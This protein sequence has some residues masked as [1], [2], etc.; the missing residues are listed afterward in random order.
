MLIALIILGAFFY[1]QTGYQLGKASWNV[2]HK[3]DSGSLAA[4]L[5]FPISSMDKAVGVSGQA[6]IAEFAD[7]KREQYQ[8]LMA[9]SWPWKFACN[10]VIVAAIGLLVGG[11]KLIQGPDR[12]ITRSLER[13]RLR[14][15][16]RA[17]LRAA[18]E[19]AH[20]LPEDSEE[21]AIKLSD[22]Y[23]HLLGEEEK[24]RSRRLEIE[25][26][27]EFEKIRDARTRL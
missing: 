27:P 2:W 16:E 26:H 11:R 14:K 17:R 22:E 20:L 7:I 6:F 3:N 18:E 5:L 4:R 1:L 10:F 12:L 23:W 21:S 9:V 25:S 24:F 19:Q 15:E 13:R 8:L